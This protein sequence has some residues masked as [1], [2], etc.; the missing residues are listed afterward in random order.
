MG[1]TIKTN[2]FVNHIAAAVLAL[3]MFLAGVAGNSME[4][5]AA[6]TTAY[7]VLSSTKYAKVY[8]LAASGNTIPYT[9]KNLN[10]R[11]TETYGKSGSAYISNKSDELYLMQVGC[12]S[13]KYW[14]KVS[15]PIG[16]KRAIAYI[17]LSAITSNNGSHAKST[18]SGKFY[19]YQRST[20]ASTSSSYYV[21]K[22]DTVYLIATSGTKYQIMYPTSNGQYRIAWCNKSDYD[23]YCSAASGSS[24]NSSSDLIQAPMK[25]YGIYVTFSKN[26]SY[27][28][29][30][31]N[32]HIGVDYYAKGSDKNVYAA[33]A[34]TVKAA[35]YNSANGYYVI[36]QHTISGK[37]VYSF[38]AHLASYSV[39]AGDKVSVGSKIGVVGKSGSSANGTVH[40]HFAFVDTYKSAGSYYGYASSFTGNK[41]KYSG[42]TYYNPEYVIQ[43]DRLP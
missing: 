18:A 41:T 13:G 24:N 25:N 1:K 11:G 19:C 17:P 6:S 14:A 42:V 34:G 12:T 9:N 5:Q 36:I 2:M 40:L 43:Y 38:Y 21:A 7:T 22:G 4:V 29:S 31:R 30:S 28:P 23:K 16:S 27:M 33:A 3:V 10:V 35:G 8:T 15:Y 26:V 39:K 32:D 20:S 37:T